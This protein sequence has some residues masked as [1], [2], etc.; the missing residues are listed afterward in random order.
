MWNA[1]GVIFCLPWSETC[2]P[3]RT[4]SSSASSGSLHRHLPPDPGICEGGRQHRYSDFHQELR[5]LRL[6][7]GS[8]SGSWTD[9]GVGGTA[10]PGIS[11]MPR[12]WSDRDSLRARSGPR[13]REQRARWRPPPPPLG[14]AATQRDP[15]R[16]SPKRH[17]R[18]PEQAP[19]LLPPCP[20]ASVPGARG[21][22]G[23]GS[24]RA[25]ARRHRRSC[26]PNWP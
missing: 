5:I 11:W 12:P 8:W 10:A 2:Q 18:A 7:A 3:R 23:G 4:S 24:P 14:R 21:G 1:E 19:Q 15:R 20:L 6:S 25:G 16:P 17:S 26:S 13:I 22:E 9:C